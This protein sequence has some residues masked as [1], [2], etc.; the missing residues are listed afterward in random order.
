M[1]RYIFILLLTSF[2]SILDLKTTKDHLDSIFEP[3]IHLI[4]P[5]TKLTLLT[6]SIKLELAF[7]DPL[8]VST[9]EIKTPTDTISIEPVGAPKEFLTSQ[10]FPIKNSGSYNTSH[11]KYNIDISYKN[12]DG[13]TISK[14]YTLTI[15][16]LSV[17]YL[18]EYTPTKPAAGSSWAGNEQMSITINNTGAPID[19]IE[20]EGLLGSKTYNA[21]LLSNPFLIT[22]N[23]LT[24]TVPTGL[25][26]VWVRIISK[27]GGIATESFALP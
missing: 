25:V 17:S 23:S 4:S 18:F 16:L 19:R 21:P 3:N 5:S 1:L 24:T 14:K 6:D 15:K 12:T 26:H 10:V 20:I 2:C 22:Y 8:G 27:N 13:I 7:Q 9:I 11:G